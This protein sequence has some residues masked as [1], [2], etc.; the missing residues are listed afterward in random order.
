MLENTV[1]QL[2]ST[3]NE[4]QSSVL[5]LE[6]EPL[7]SNLLI[8]G[9]PEQNAEKLKDI[10]TAVFHS[11]DDKVKPQLTAVSRMGQK[12]DQK[13]RPILVKLSSSAMKMQLLTEKRKKQLA[14]SDIVVNGKCLGAATDMIFLGEHLAPINSRLFYIARQLVKKN[15]LLHAWARDGHI[16][17]RKAED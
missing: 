3:V 2:R 14:C 11:I 8:R 10:V 12:N 1:V 17:V 7:N 5:R 4:L 16:F 6:Q 9:I 13:N 15:E